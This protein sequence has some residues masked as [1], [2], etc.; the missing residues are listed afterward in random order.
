MWQTKQL[1]IDPVEDHIVGYGKEAS[2][3]SARPQSAGKLIVDIATGEASEVALSPDSPAVEFARRG[4]MKG[5]KARAAN[6]TPDRRKL[7][8]AP[9]LR[10]G[11]R[12]RKR[13]RIIE[14]LL[15]VRYDYL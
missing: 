3:A 12:P 15:G 10:A 6:M 4:G 7:P 11:S 8:N 13:T 5:G 14:Y 1:G 9:L 2:P